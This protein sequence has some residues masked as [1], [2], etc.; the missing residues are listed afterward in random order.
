MDANK[1]WRALPRS[2]RRTVT[3]YLRD[4]RDFFLELD[5]EQETDAYGMPIEQVRKAMTIALAVLGEQR[6]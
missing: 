2:M 3:R 1:R 6:R 5:D 4:D